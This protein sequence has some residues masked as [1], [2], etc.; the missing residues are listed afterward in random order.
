[1]VSEIENQVKH[2]DN[3]PNKRIL[4]IIISYDVNNVA[5]PKHAIKTV[6]EIRYAKNWWIK[7]LLLGICTAGA[8]RLKYCALRTFAESR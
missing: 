5:E 3:G 7:L 2:E 6:N 4:I 1:M 8:L